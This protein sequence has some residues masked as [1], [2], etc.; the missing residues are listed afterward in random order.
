MISLFLNILIEHSSE[1]S[2]TGII[3]VYLASDFGLDAVD[4]A[5]VLENNNTNIKL[6]A[7]ALEESFH[8]LSCTLV[9][10]LMHILRIISEQFLDFLGGSIFNVISNP[11][12]VSFVAPLDSVKSHTFKD[13]DLLKFN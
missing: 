12:D 2:R 4:S 3:V 7:C 1:D 6:I 10:G 5:A 13:F 11:L 8:H 9:E